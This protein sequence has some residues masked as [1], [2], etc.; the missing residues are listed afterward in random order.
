MIVTKGFGIKKYSI[1]K[2]ILIYCKLI[3][4]TKNDH[5]VLKCKKLDEARFGISSYFENIFF[6]IYVICTN[7]DSI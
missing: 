1:Q 7:S 2:P 3:H 4:K 6:K 5:Y